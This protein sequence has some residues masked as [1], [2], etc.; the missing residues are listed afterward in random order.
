MNFKRVWELLLNNVINFTVFLMPMVFFQPSLDPFGPVQMMTARIFLP[1]ITLIFIIRSMRDG[2][3][4]LKQNPALLPLIAYLLAAFVSVFFSVNMEVSFK[5]LIDMTV[6]ILG[7]YMVFSAAGAGGIKKIVFMII[8]SHTLMAAYGIAQHFNADPFKWSTNFTG[9]PLG[10]IGN[11]DFFAGEL[12]VPFFIIAAYALYEKKLRLWAVAALVIHAVC[13]YYTRVAGVFIGLGFG[14][15]A[16][17]VAAAFISREKIAAVFSAHKKKLI[18]GMLAVIAIA[19]ILSPFVISKFN[20][21]AA[22]KERSLKHRLIMWESSLLMAAESPLLGKGLGSFR[23]NYP[24]YQGILLNNP[25]NNDYDYV[26]TWMPHQQYLLIAS[27]TGIIGLGLFLLAIAAFYRVTAGLIRDK[28]AGFIALGFASSVTALLGASFF[29]TFYN[30]ASTTFF[31]FLMLFAQHAFSQKISFYPV[32]KKT[33]YGMLAAVSFALIMLING[34]G[35]TLAANMYLKKADSFSKIDS[36]LSKAIEYYERVIG[37]KAVELCPQTDVAQ[38]YY[39]AEAYRKA[40]YLEKAAGY[41]RLDLKLNPYCPE[42]NNMLGALSG[43]LGNLDESI[44]LLETAVF[45]AP[46]YDAAYTNLATAYVSKKDYAGAKR[47]LSKFMEK[48]G[49]KPEFESMLKAVESMMKTDL[50]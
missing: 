12:L 45:T 14:A 38:Y 29:N 3:V 15:V 11:P 36:M 6:M 7:A 4:L 33:A 18:A 37:L 19:V 2:R 28:R 8:L 10:T 41:Y 31:F 30:I 21:F 49:S 25:K 40:G 43:Q 5:Y 35:R 39:A 20:K 48:N 47:T 44:K 22:E 1:L 34:D 46:H 17:V 9:R 50:K 26:V 23:M 24:Y 13:I 27:E 16:F 32:K 42:V